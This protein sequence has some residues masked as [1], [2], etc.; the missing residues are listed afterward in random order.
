MEG[1]DVLKLVESINNAKQEKE[2]KERKKKEEIDLFYD[3]RKDA[4]LTK[5]FAKLLN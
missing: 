5:E 2:E 3:A 1:K 4:F